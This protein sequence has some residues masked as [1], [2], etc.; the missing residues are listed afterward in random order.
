MTLEIIKRSKPKIP[1]STKACIIF[2]IFCLLI[3]SAIFIVAYISMSKNI[4]LDQYNQPLLS[5]LVEHRKTQITYA[6]SIVTTFA[7]SF[8]LSSLVGAIAIIWALIKREIWRPALL[9]GAISICP[10]ISSV[11]KTIVQNTRPDQLNMIQPFE[12][13]YSFPSGHTLGIIVLLLVLGYLIIS[14]HTSDFRITVWSIITVALT[15]LIAFSRLYLGYHWLTDVVA[16]IGLG[17]I[18]LSL[19]VVADRF[20]IH[21]FK[22]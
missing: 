14:R 17:F 11:T 13:D 9:V 20:F 1:W 15:A 4:L 16:S 10:I 22:N 19:A 18:I 5:W 6:L 21:I 12:L 3:G 2:S 7:G 8:Y